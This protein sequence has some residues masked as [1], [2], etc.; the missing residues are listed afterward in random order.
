MLGRG[1]RSMGKAGGGKKVPLSRGGEL[2]FQLS[3]LVDF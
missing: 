3:A 1:R 2:L